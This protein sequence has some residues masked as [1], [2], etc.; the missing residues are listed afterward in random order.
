MSERGRHCRQE[1]N[2]CVPSFFKGDIKNNDD[3]DDDDDNVFAIKHCSSEFKRGIAIRHC[4]NDDVKSLL[5]VS[6]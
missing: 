6:L 4:L 2:E 5:I 3:D 1:R